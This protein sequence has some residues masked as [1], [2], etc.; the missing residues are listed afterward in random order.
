QGTGAPLARVDPF[1]SYPN[2]FAT[3]MTV[4]DIGGSHGQFVSEALR[5]FPAAKIY[6]FE[7]LPECFEELQQ[8][9]RQ[10][11]ALHPRQLALSDAAGFDDFNVSSFSDS[12]SF[13]RMLPKHLE[14]WPHTATK[15][16]IRVEKARLDDQFDPVEL[17]RPIFIKIDVQ[18]HELQVIRGGRQVLAASQRV[19]IECNFAN[20]YDGQPGFDELH[21]E[22]RELGFL[23]DCLISPLR[24]PVTGEL[25]SSDLIYFRPLSDRKDP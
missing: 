5:A 10:H 9:A 17:A 24:H 4:I 3:P 8:I 13:Q 16:C 1:G 7:P 19:M 12:S 2:R 23:L 15:E 18:G 20:L 14:A 6:S 11:P 22:M 25:M 21:R